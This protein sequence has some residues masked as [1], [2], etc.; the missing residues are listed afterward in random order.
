MKTT[1]QNQDQGL[2]SR[3]EQLGTNTGTKH[4]YVYEQIT[5]RI[6]AMLEKGEIPWK[7]TWKTRSAWPCN[8][9]SKRPYQGINVFL[10]HAMSYES[11]FWLTYRQAQELGG[12]VRKG[13]KACPVIFCKRFEVENEKTGEVEKVPVLRFYHVFNSSQCENLKNVPTMPE[14]PAS[15]PTRPEEIVAQ[16]PTRPEI[17]HGRRAAFYS[18]TE[19]II[20]MP[21]K[22]RFDTEAAYFSTLYHEM[23]HSTG[24]RHRLNRPGVAENSGFGTDPY[25]KEE[26]I[27]E[28][29]AAYLCSQAGIVDSTMENSASYIQGWLKKMQE[30]KKLIVQAASQAQKA[31]NFILG[32]TP[33]EAP[34]ESRETATA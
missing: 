11:P 5:E 15:E 34:A 8:L 16:M 9:V 20:G 17:K 4:G 21:D 32:I 22:A 28:M 31:A 3:P 25:S 26:L 33:E 24:A 12:N 14:A 7:K 18:P 1:I 30:D 10:L 13:E 6:V 27:A 19:D 23:I 2:Q 29:G